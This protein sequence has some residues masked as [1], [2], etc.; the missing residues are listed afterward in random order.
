MII[1][2]TDV[3]IDFLA[4]KDPGAGRVGEELQKGALYTTVISRF[5]LL[6]GSKNMK[7]N[8][9]V[10]QLLEALKILTLD[11]PAADRAAEVRR[12]L[13]QK[14]HGIG[15]ADSLIAGIVL[16]HDAHLLTRNDQHFNRVHGLKLSHWR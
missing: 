10:E 16:E 4:G 3:L 11:V 1:A 7:Q 13:D 12:H 2:D 8:Q 14:G 15:M 6:S 5:E 9:K